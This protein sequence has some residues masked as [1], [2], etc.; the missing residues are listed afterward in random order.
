[1]NRK[2]VWKRTK[3]EFVHR[4]LRDTN[5]NVRVQ[6]VEGIFKY[7]H[8]KSIH[9]TSLDQY[10]LAETIVGQG[11]FPFGHNF[12]FNWLKCIMECADQK[13]MEIFWSKRNTFGCTSLSPIQPDGMEIN[14]SFAQNYFNFHFCSLLGS[15]LRHHFSFL[16]T[17][18]I[19]NLERMEKSHSI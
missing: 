18:E 17:N 14:V 1:M 5:M 2:G 7:I 10:W 15:S 13:L 9:H 6:N 16:S 4:K 19:A 12:Q 11:H 8:D 3:K